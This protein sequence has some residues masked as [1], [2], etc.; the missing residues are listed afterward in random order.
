MHRDKSK[1]IAVALVV[2]LAAAIGLGVPAFAKS[3]HGGKGKTAASQ[4]T[5]GVKAQRERALNAYGSVGRSPTFGAP[6][7]NNPALTGGGST[8]YNAN[9]YIY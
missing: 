2:A 4:T 6:N 5:H 7:P 3:T 9:L 1:L 8:G